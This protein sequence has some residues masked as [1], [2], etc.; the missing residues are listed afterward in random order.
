MQPGCLR[1]H[2]RLS[3]AGAD[4]GVPEIPCQRGPTAHR[5]QYEGHCRKNSGYT[6]APLLWLMSRLSLR[7]LSSHPDPVG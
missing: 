1:L 3:D 5:C 7:L 6:L 2:L 4:R